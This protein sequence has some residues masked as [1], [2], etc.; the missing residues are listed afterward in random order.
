MSLIKYKIRAVEPFC[1]FILHK[2]SIEFL[3]NSLG[4][5]IGLKIHIEHQNSTRPQLWAVVGLFEVL[6]YNLGVT[7]MM[8][9]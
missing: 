7:E 6:N 8:V 2:G 1:L 9:D 4:C 5:T 3:L